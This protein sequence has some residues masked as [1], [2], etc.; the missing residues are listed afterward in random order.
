MTTDS[1][2]ADCEASR[3]SGQPLLAVDDVLQIIHEV[4]VYSKP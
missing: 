3:R 1:V 2:E 4:S